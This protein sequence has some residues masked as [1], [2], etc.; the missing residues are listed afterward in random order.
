MQK[1]QEV[2]NQELIQRHPHDIECS[3]QVCEFV[4][5]HQETGKVCLMG[6]YL[7]QNGPI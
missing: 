3:E 1:R 6:M 7:Q 4:F 2:C 5:S